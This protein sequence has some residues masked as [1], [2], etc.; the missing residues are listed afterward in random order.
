[1]PDDRETYLKARAA[2]VGVAAI[3]ELEEDGDINAEE[4]GM[5][6]AAKGFDDSFIRQRGF[7]PPDNEFILP[8]E[9]ETIPTSTGF[10]PETINYPKAL[11]AKEKIEESLNPIEWTKTE[12]RK[13]FDSI[14]ERFNSAVSS[15]TGQLTRLTTSLKNSVSS[16]IGNVI[17]KLTGFISG[18]WN[19]INNIIG[20]LA[21][22]V[23][24]GYDALVTITKNIGNSIVSLGTT[25]KESVTKA[26]IASSAAIARFFTS[27]LDATL[28]KIN[29]MY[30]SL[31]DFSKGL[32]ETFR[33]NFRTAINVFKSGIEGVG[34]AVLAG[35]KYLVDELIRTIAYIVDDL[36][37]M[38]GVSTEAIAESVEVAMRAGM[39]LASQ[40]GE[41]LA[42]QATAP[43]VSTGPIPTATPRRVI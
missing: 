5:M 4:A 25:I 12:I 3:D 31:R 8:D 11:A 7:T 28:G 21:N 40:L 15:M 20:D 39:T 17:D 23:R 27:A 36:N 42:A 18:I 10:S 22:T 24:R 19:G 32:Q 34:S 1:M 14:L 37:N 13:I 16:V 26:I 35:F 6:L 43:T 30:Q 29:D 9:Y 38:L 2:I 41:E 33:E